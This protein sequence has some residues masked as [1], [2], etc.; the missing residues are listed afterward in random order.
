MSNGLKID[1]LDV[2]V[3]L[4]LVHVGG[5]G[6]VLFIGEEVVYFVIHFYKLSI[7]KCNL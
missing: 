6:P 4:D 3:V 2:D 5:L 7:I 1:L